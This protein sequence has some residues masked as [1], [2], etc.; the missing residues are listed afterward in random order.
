MGHSGEFET[1]MME[2]LEPES[3][4]VLKI[5]SSL[6]KL[7]Y[8]FT[9]DLVDRGPVFVNLVWS[10]LT[11]SG[12]IGDAT[13]ANAAKGEQ[14]FEAVCETAVEAVTDFI[15]LNPGEVLAD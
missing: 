13:L 4:R 2:H 1:S 8:P 14:L 3:V 10:Q 7:P 15:K 5:D 6:P 12:A 11:E 9:P